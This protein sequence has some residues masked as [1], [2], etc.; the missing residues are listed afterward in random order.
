[1][2]KDNDTELFDELKSS[3]IE[4]LEISKTNE[5]LDVLLTNSSCDETIIESS[6]E[7]NNPVEN[8]AKSVVVPL[9]TSSYVKNML[10]EAMTEKQEMIASLE[11]PREHSPISSERY[12]ICCFISVWIKGEIIRNNDF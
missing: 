1:M 5:M 4:P 7:D 3:T 6:S 11:R 12:I 9:S 2:Q 8:A 10:A